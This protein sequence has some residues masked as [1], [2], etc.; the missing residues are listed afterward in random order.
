MNAERAQ[1]GTCQ[2]NILYRTCVFCTYI[3]WCQLTH[4]HECWI[5]SMAYSC[6]ND[7]KLKV[8]V[9][10]QLVYCDTLLHDHTNLRI[11]SDGKVFNRR[12]SYISTVRWYWSVICSDREFILS[13]TFLV[14][15][16]LKYYQDKFYMH[17]RLDKPVQIMAN[18]KR[19]F[20]IRT[21]LC[22]EALHQFDT[23]CIKIEIASMT[24]FKQVVLGLGIYFSPVIFFLNKCA[25][26]P[27]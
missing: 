5:R 4:L 26:C 19:E 12:M 13:V 7:R 17:F 10:H 8:F 16:Y 15:I 24:H 1:Y 6:P 3:V 14:L 9:T 20:N 23:L 27:A 21:L 18:T 11:F 22:G 25:Q 2:R